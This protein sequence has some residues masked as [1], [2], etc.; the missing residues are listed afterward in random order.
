M[1]GKIKE[2]MKKPYEQFIELVNEAK[3]E[4]E[5]CLFVD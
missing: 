1:S 4:I 2:Q 3:P 5:E